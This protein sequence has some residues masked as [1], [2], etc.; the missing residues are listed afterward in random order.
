MVVTSSISTQNPARAVSRA[1][2]AVV[3]TALFFAISDTFAQVQTRNLPPLEVTWLRYLSFMVL[4]L[5]WKRHVF[6][7]GFRTS[8]YGWQIWRGLFTVGSAI[9][10]VIGLHQLPIGDATAIAFSAP[11]MIMALSVPLLREKVGLRRWAAAA[12][13]L[14]GVLI[15]VR[16]GT[17][18]FQWASLLPF[19]AALF[20]ALSII[21]TRFMQNETSAATLTYTGIVG[22]VV[23]SCMVPFVW[24]TPSLEDAAPI[25]ITGVAAFLA[26]ITLIAAYRDVPVAIAAPFSYVQLVFAALLGFL[27][28]GTLPTAVSVAGAIIIA[29]S[30]FFSAYFERRESLRGR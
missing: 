8:L 21:A 1:I 27:I 17:S 25:L 22:F 23:L 5:L 10:F 18:S 28:A 16:P 11:F 19:F 29:V 14:A 13:G 9:F 2:V 26:N 30:G 4:L 24:V 7:A 20:T 6:I 15:S 12:I 3:L